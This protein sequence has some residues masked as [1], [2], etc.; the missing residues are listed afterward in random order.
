[1]RFTGRLPKVEATGYSRSILAGI[2]LRVSEV[3]HTPRAHASP[4]SYMILGIK[5]I[6]ESLFYPFSNFNGFLI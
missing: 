4:R 5:M 6:G 2:F 3:T 1:M